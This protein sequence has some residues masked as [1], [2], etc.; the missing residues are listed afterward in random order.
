MLEAFFYKRDY[1]NLTS[2]SVFDKITS[3]YEVS[4]IEV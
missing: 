1:F 3:S 2:V 4:N